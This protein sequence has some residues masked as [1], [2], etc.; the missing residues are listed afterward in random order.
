MYTGARELHTAGAH[1]TCSCN[2]TS[3]GASPV[4]PGAVSALK[5]GVCTRD[6]SASRLAS[7]RCDPEGQM[8]YGPEAFFS[9]R[10]LRPGGNN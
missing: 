5:V 9:R 4:S 7:L 1:T 3:S 8:C 2:C 6:L 10:G